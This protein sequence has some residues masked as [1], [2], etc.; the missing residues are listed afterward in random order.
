MCRGLGCPPDISMATDLAAMGFIDACAKI[1]DGGRDPGSNFEIMCS[2]TF[3]AEAPF[4]PTYAD[5]LRAAP[6]IAG[7]EPGSS[8][9]DTCAAANSFVGAVKQAEVDLKL[10]MSAVGA[11]AQPVERDVPKGDTQPAPQAQTMYTFAAAS[12]ALPAM[13]VRGDLFAHCT[14]QFR[15]IVGNRK[16][17]S[18]IAYVHA[19]R[20]WCGK[21]TTSGGSDAHPDWDK[22]RCIGMESLLAFALRDDMESYSIDSIPEQEVCRRLF[23]A[24]GSVHRLDK[25]VQERI[26]IPAHLQPVSIP[27]VPPPPAVPVGPTLPPANDGP[28]S[29][30]WREASV[31][32]DAAQ[33][34]LAAKLAAEKAKDDGKEVVQ[35]FSEGLIRRDDGKEVDQTIAVHKL[36]WAQLAQQEPAA[37]VVGDGAPVF[38]PSVDDFDSE[39]DRL[40]AERLQRLRGL[41]R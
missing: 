35:K 31:E 23:L 20:D 33:A 17:K 27:T 21:E 8:V 25:I 9:K 18:G 22:T 10:C 28:M 1:A 19:T 32:Q 6:V 34:K 15:S 41:G 26:V 30:L 11:I 7:G 14:D 13:E 24:I 40:S 39:S 36:V 38:L 3:P 5:I 37:S 12:K 4:C 29:M 2:S 16:V